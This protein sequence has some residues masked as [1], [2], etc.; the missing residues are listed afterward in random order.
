MKRLLELTREELVTLSEVEIKDLIDLECMYNGKPVMVDEP[1]YIEVPTM[2]E[3]DVETFEVSGHV[4]TNT[5]DAIKVKELIESLESRSKLD[6]SSSNYDLKLVRKLSDY[7]YEKPITIKKGRAYSKET[8]ALVKPTLDKIKEI[9]ASNAKLK[10]AYDELLECRSEVETK[11]YDAISNAKDDTYAI[12]QAINAYQKYLRLSN[13]DSK[14]AMN[15]F[16][17]SDYAKYTDE[18]NESLENNGDT[19]CEK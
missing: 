5:S 11:V 8:Y 17:E 2:P 15:F 10:E 16:K 14:V 13:N 18:V 19:C 3:M 12:N 6:Y 7:D 4:F 9:N 1:D